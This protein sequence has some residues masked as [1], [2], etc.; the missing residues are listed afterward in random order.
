MNTTIWMNKPA[1]DWLEGLPIGTG[2]LAAMV[3][4]GV[5]REQVTLNHEWLWTGRNRQRDTEPR[6][7]LL[8][9]V[10]ELLRQ[11]RWEE[12]AQAANDAFGGAGGI[13]GVRNRVDPYQPAADLLLTFSHGPYHHYRRSLDLESGIVRVEYDAQHGNRI[14][15]TYVA[16][17][18]HDAIYVHVAFDEYPLEC[19]VQLDRGFDPDCTLTR[20]AAGSQLDLHGAIRD[21]IEFHVRCQAAVREGTVRANGDNRLIVSGARELLLALDLGT[22][23]KQPDAAAECDAPLPSLD[24]WPDLVRA[25][26]ETYQR[27]R[28]GFSLELGDL[29]DREAMPTPER[30]HRARNGEPDPGLPLLYFNLARHLMQASS[31]LADLPANLQGKWNEDLRPPWECDLHQDVNLQMNYWFAEPAGMTECIE[32]L[33]RHIERFVPHARKAA[34]DLYG[35]RG[36]WFPIQTDPW[37]RATPE[38]YG[39][40]VWIGAAAWLAQHFWWRWDF[41]RDRQFLADRAYPFIKDVAAF[42]EDYLVADAEGVLQVMPSQSPENRFV[43]SGSRFPVSIGISAAMD[44]ELAHECLRHAVA[45]SEALGVDEDLRRTWQDMLGQ[46]PPLQVGSRGQLLEWDREFEEVEPGHRHLSHLYA[47]Y[48]GDQIDPLDSPELFTAARR[49][50]EIRLENFG[51]HTGWSRAWTACCFAR[52]GD[53]EAAWAHLMHLA[54]DFVTDALLDLHPPRIFQIEGNFGGAAAILEMLLQSRGGRLHLLPALPEVWPSGEVKGLR[55]R[56]GFVVDMKWAAGRLMEAI[57]TAQET[58]PC[59]IIHGDQDQTV[60]LQAGETYQVNG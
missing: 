34:R 43:G 27:G 22:N 47:L 23:V 16:D 9:P 39:W 30:I 46:L 50:L 37:G 5:K 26:T 40:A 54:T 19:V 49:S 44:V 14:T 24:E 32:A 18:S 52:L 10:R 20:R 1:A 51:G 57:V 25:H 45:A 42:Y 59:R 28:G 15:R 55:A 36:V 58:G 33:F 7:H 41:G 56:G 11:E 3:L 31:A 21:G 35:C 60:T 12:A 13:S 4:G 29:P 53:A 8:E 38:S 48:P 17:L 6:A 2:R